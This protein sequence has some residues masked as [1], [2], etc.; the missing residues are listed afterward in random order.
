MSMVTNDAR[1]ETIEI[2]LRHVTNIATT[3]S[4]FEG[5]CGAI[6]LFL[7]LKGSATLLN[8]FQ[9]LWSHFQIPLDGKMYLYILKSHCY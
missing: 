6:C 4:M 1:R 9:T 2:T 7:V 5:F 8:V 3:I